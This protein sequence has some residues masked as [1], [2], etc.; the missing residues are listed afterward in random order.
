MRVCWLATEMLCH[1]IR[2]E[3]LPIKGKSYSC[4]V[5]WATHLRNDLKAVVVVSH[6]IFLLA[7]AS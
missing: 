4:F 5:N 3:F 7:A 1:F 2:I 6:F